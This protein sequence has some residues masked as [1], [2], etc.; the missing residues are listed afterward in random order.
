MTYFKN[1][2]E[3]QAIFG[4]NQ[5]FMILKK[6]KNK[7]NAYFFFKS[8]IW[9]I[10]GITFEFEVKNTKQATKAMQKAQLNMNT[11]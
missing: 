5:I 1:K 11:T 4:R 8:N 2:T 9:L 3:F 10:D 7:I 6:N